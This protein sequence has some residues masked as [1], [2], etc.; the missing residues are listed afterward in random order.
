MEPLA[1]LQSLWPLLA[2]LVYVMVTCMLSVLASA[3]HHEVA[4]HDLVKRARERRL[5][6]LRAMAAPPQHEEEVGSER[7]SRA[8]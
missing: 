8:A 3:H 6:Y 1:V 2:L 7:P 4:R 5:E